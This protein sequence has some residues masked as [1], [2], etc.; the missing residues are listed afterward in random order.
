MIYLFTTTQY[1]GQE[2]EFITH[3]YYDKNNDKYVYVEGM[4]RTTWVDIDLYYCCVD[5]PNLS[6]NN[7]AKF[8][9]P[10]DLVYVSVIKI[11][12]CFCDS[13]LLDRIID[14]L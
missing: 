2:S 9:I 10:N 12:T 5:E 3:Y 4:S 8:T 6:N 13:I 1:V 14:T 7:R 11:D